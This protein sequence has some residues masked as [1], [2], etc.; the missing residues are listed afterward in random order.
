MEN[1]IQTLLANAMHFNVYHV[2][3]SSVCFHTFISTSVGVLRL[4]GFDWVQTDY[5]D[6]SDLITRNYDK[7]IYSHSSV[8]DDATFW[9]KGIVKS[10]T[11]VE[12]SDWD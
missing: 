11:H 10:K 5:K 7:P 9:K 6:A 4:D 8:V 1:T 2:F 3:K 12:L